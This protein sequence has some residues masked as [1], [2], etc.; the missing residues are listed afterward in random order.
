MTLA[1][2]EPTS[3]SFSMI[4]SRMIG[5]TALFRWAA[6][7]RSCRSTSFGSRTAT[8][9]SA[10][11]TPVVVILRFP[12][13]IYLRPRPRR[14]DLS[15]VIPLSQIVFLTPRSAVRHNETI[16]K[17]I[18][19]I[20]TGHSAKTASDGYGGERPSVL[21][22]A[23]EDICKDLLDVDLGAAMLRLVG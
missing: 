1:P 14:G 17:D 21:M 13:N 15:C 18:Y 8:R 16:K 12:A 7:A 23:N 4:H 10:T 22:K 6:S 19:E 9:V 5:A 20:I 11:P 2:R 3:R